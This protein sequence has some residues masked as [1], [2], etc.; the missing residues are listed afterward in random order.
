MDAISM[1][2]QILNTNKEGMYDT[3]LGEFVIWTYLFLG[4]IHILG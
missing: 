2:Y 4:R 1:Y 3:Q